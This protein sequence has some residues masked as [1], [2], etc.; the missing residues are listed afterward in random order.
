M[1]QSAWPHPIARDHRN[2]RLDLSRKKGPI[3]SGRMDLS[4]AKV[5]SCAHPRRNV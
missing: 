4:R 3:D 2:S 5:L 1:V